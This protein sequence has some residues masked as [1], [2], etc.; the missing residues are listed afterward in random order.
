M[1]QMIAIQFQLTKS[2]HTLFDRHG[3]MAQNMLCC[4]YQIQTQLMWRLSFVLN[5]N[6]FV[7]AITSKRSLMSTLLVVMQ[8]FQVCFFLNNSQLCTIS[9]CLSWFRDTQI[10]ISTSRI[11][12]W[13]SWSQGPRQTAPQPSFHTRIFWPPVFYLVECLINS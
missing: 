1:S 12:F 7:N 2:N 4:K 5:T 3:S 9:S 11:P 6:S 8:R 10:F 13:V